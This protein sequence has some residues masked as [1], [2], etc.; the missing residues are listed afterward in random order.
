MKMV[1]LLGSPRKRGNTELLVD[2]FAEGA[3]SGGAEFE[4]VRLQDLEFKGCRA[5]LACHKTG[6]CHQKDDMLGVYEKLLQADV[7]V[8]ATPV[9]WWGPTAQIKAA[10]DR[11]YSLCYGDH[12]E[13]IK[14]KKFVL[15][16]ASADPV[17][18]A[19][20]YLRGMLKKSCGFLKM[21]WAG[22]IAAQAGPKG[23][24]AG[25]KKALLKARSLGRKVARIEQ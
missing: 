21:K 16:T 15:V 7:W 10:I 5:C 22:E 24:V 8:M 20:P 3:R 23:E 6:Q 19:A 18:I 14:G 9:Y 25:N 1:A 13:Q 2:A 4:K 12:P 17:K 11:F